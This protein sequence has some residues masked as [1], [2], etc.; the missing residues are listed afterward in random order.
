MSKQIVL[1]QPRGFCAGV[2]RAIKTLDLVLKKTDK[3]VYVRHQI[4]H[5]RRVVRDYEAKGVK[6]VESLKE[7]P[8][9]SIVV[10]S[11]HGTPPEVFEKAKKKKLLVVDGVCPLVTK[12]HL[13]ARRLVGEGYFVIY[14][15]HRGH[16]EA[17]GV[18]GEIPKDKNLLVENIKEAEECR[19]P[20]GVKKVGVLT[21]TTLNYDEALRI[22][23]RLQERWPDLKLPSGGDI[24][25]AT[26]GRQRAV[27]E[28]AKQ[29]DVVIVVGSKESSNS[30]KLRDRVKEQGVE[31]YLVD[32][33]SQ[34]RPEWFKGKD[35]IGVTAGASGPGYLV[36]E[37]VEEIK[38]FT[39][40]KIRELIIQ[41]DKVVL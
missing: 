10:L 29:T 30:N 38:R 6:F 13:E 36:E 37:I 34:I 14:I 9:G 15:G 22:I 1:V 20:E 23:E 39:K 4:V 40:G 5:N 31:G 26:K 24:C 21:Q 28:L 2:S 35:K 17:V 11:A 7:V 12:V 16:Q 33:A 27:I 41:E 25:Y 19:V 32:D 18:L 3:Q 8:E